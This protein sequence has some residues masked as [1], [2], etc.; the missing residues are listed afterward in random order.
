MHL[1]KRKNGIYYIH[2]KAKNGNWKLLS[3]KTK[4][5]Y[6]AQKYF[7]NFIKKYSPEKYLNKKT[8]FESFA[9]EYLEYSKYNHSPS[10]TTRIDYVIN[11][12]KNYI[13]SMQLSEVNSKVVETFKKKR[14]T[15]CKPT[16]VNIELRALKSMFNTAID[17]NLI[18]TN[19]LRGIQMLRVPKTYPKYL[20]DEEVKLLCNTTNFEWL[21]NL[22]LFA[23]NTGMRR[24]EIINLKWEDINLEEK[25]LIVRN[26]DTFSTK[27]KKDRIIPLS[28]SV[29]DLLS[30]ICKV[31]EYVFVNRMRLQLYPNYVTQCF[32]D[33]VKDCGLK[34]GISFHTLRHSFASM[35]VSKGV[36]LYIVKELLG[37][38]DFAT[39][40]IYAHLESK[41]LKDAINVL[42]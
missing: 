33:L 34:K 28:I 18:D 24:N 22:I 41:S 16:T 42:N 27:S 3:T 36:S 17:W 9:K 7:I 25:Y 14:V 15:L 4:K 10:N 19:P 31:S 13:G 23:F 40:Q 11:H 8:T 37:H 20:T 12:F 26:N 6:E 38:S 32:R 5:S 1:Y 2:F 35:L 21:K 39:T 30:T 29:I